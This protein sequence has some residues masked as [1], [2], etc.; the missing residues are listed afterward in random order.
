MAH[1]QMAAERAHLARAIALAESARG[2]SSPNPPVGCVLVADGR[3][4]G[5]GATRPVGG[6]HAEAVAL[7]RMRPGT[8]QDSGDLAAYVTLEPCAHVGRTPSCAEALVDAGVTR[9]VIGRSDPHRV[10]AGGADR[11]RAAGVTV[12][13]LDHDDPYLRALEDPLAGH[14]SVSML[15]RPHVTLKLA[16]TVSG[17]L[18]RDDGGW[19]T[20]SAARRAVH[21]LRAT[22]DGVLVGSG[23]VLSDDPRLDV[24]GDD[25]RA[26]PGR[27]PRAV[28]FDTDLRTPVTARVV[29]EG[30]IVVTSTADAGHLEDR[31]VDVV[32]VERSGA[33]VDLAA[34]MRALVDRGVTTLLAEPGRTL[35]DALV[36]H[37]L[38]DRLVL[39]VADGPGTL[40]AAVEVDARWELE[41]LGGVGPDAVLQWRHLRPVTA[42]DRAA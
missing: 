42:E 33:H 31:G 22:V 12:D 20:G 5:E 8:G 37:E 30:T 24:R 6:P 1:L 3:V 26:K 29:R 21:R 4:V 19:V 23:T 17:A 25:G 16:Q 18:V 9:V 11:L 38:V 15:G 32:C 14:L 27:Q 2:V 10:A 13:I 34:A 36:V 39:H 41:R 7:A 40:Q 28:V 35:A